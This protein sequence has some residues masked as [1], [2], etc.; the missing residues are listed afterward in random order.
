MEKVTAEMRNE[1]AT[2]GSDHFDLAT[3]HKTTIVVEAFPSIMEETSREADL[4]ASSSPMQ[5]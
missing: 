5:V 2:F 3:A 4:E 1:F